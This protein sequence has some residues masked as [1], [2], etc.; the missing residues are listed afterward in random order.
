M[1]QIGK[2][3]A[4]TISLLLILVLVMPMFGSNDIKDVQAA[5]R[6]HGIQQIINN[7]NETDKFTILEIV[8]DKA[9]ASL[10]YYV[11]GSE[12]NLDT[13][14]IKRLLSYSLPSEQPDT[15]VSGYS[16]RKEAVKGYLNPIQGENNIVSYSEDTMYSER[17][18]LT[19]DMTDWNVITAEGTTPF[20]EIRKGYF[21]LASSMKLAQGD[22]TFTPDESVMLAEGE[23]SSGEENSEENGDSTQV[24]GTFTYT[25]GVGEYVW[26]D[27][28]ENGQF[29]VIYFEKLY[30]KVDV[31]SND[32]FAENVLELYIN[33]NA[34]T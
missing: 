11:S 33:D 7:L 22:Y 9:Y 30:Y 29:D 20:M 2:K 17:L 19:E 4:A 34:T 15:L 6:L 28:I 10:G 27:D 32:W 8:P 31:D 13:K 18:F 3:I 24:T 21:V 26:V 23:E 12:P 1:K 16:V 14:L 5:T 25:P